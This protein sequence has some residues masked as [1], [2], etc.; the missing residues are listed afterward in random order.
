MDKSYGIVIFKKGSLLYHTSN[1]LFSY[2][3]NSEKPFLFCS[4]HPSEYGT[5]NNETYV[6]FIKI[7]KDI[8]LLFMIEK[9]KKNLI[10]SSLHLFT[11]NKRGN[12]T[13]INNSKLLLF[14]DKLKNNNFDGWITSINNKTNIEVGL[15]N[16]KSLY[17]LNKS[18]KL[19]INWENSYY[20]NNKLISKDWGLKY[21]ICTI[22]KPAVF[23]VNKRY[24]EQFEEYKKLEINSKSPSNYIFQII[25][26][27]AII[28]FIDNELKN[29]NWNK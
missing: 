7:K 28:L 9:I 15:L 8:S 22:R 17:E 10:F 19:N 11:K 23:I 20:L 12:L 18:Y 26:D 6:H 13:K 1:E 4:F 24:E 29:F 16:D 5:N 14:S 3:N 2:K 25:L 27:N 21:P